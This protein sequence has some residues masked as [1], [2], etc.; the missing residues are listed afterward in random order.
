[1]KTTTKYF[2]VGGLVVVVLFL[3]FRRRRAASAATTAAPGNDAN[4]T[5]KKWEGEVLVP[6]D[7]GGPP[8]SAVKIYP[9]PGYTPPVEPGYGG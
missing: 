2:I 1:M 6:G 5:V 4:A 8:K 3:V 9:A 7:P